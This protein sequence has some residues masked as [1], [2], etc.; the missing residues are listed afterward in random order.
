[1]Y[2]KETCKERGKTE[3]RR[4]ISAS[5]QMPRPATP[6]ITALPLSSLF[7]FV[8]IISKH[9]WTIFRNWHDLSCGFS[10]FIMYIFS[11]AQEVNGHVCSRK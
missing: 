10:W 6:S 2:E 7:V 5:V 4:Y 11:A 3:E 8:P 9:A 1:M